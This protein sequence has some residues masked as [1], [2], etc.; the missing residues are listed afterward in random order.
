MPCPRPSPGPHRIHIDV[1]VRPGMLKYSQGGRAQRVGDLVERMNSP[2]AEHLRVVARVPEYSRWMMADTRCR[3][4]SL[5]YM[6]AG[7]G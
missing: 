7:A 3:R 6:R 2:N 1:M 4:Y 5:A